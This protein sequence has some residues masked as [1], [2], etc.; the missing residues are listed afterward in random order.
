[1]V[2]NKKISIF[3]KLRRI[4]EISTYIFPYGYIYE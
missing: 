3:R 4:Q 1:M 2:Y